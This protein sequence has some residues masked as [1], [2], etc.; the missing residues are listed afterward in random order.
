MAEAPEKDQAEDGIPL[1]KV[2]RSPEAHHHIGKSQDCHSHVGTFLQ[3]HAEDP[4]IKVV[5]YFINQQTIYLTY[6]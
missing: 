2:S 4:A 6:H 3:A 1:E 5:D